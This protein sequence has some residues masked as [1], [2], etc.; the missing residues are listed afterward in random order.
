MKFLCMV[1]G[2]RWRQLG[3]WNFGGD[4]RRPS[5]I[6]AWRCDRCHHTETK[7]WDF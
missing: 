3:V 4:D 1:F 2:H 7:Q 5:S 6:T